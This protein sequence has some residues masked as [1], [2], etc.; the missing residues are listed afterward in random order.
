M[1]ALQSDIRSVPTTELELDRIKTICRPI[2]E[3]TRTRHSAFSWA[4]LF[5]SVSRGTQ[6]PDSDIDIMV[7]YSDNTNYFHHVCYDMAEFNESLP[8]AFGREVDIVPFV[9][10]EHMGYVHMEGLLTA[11]TIWGEK[12]WPE[13]DRVN[14]ERLLREG[15]VR[16]INASEMMSRLRE[17]TISY[18]ARAVHY[19][20]FSSRH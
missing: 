6:R 19:D 17:T 5:G 15:H 13:I 9:H 3:A 8:E 1:H 16:M 11:Q 20:S 7:G 4:G 14:A 2:F 12:S 10:G 18:R